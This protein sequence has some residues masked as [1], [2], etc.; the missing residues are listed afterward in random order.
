MKVPA[1]NLRQ[2]GFTLLE[3]LIATAV[4]LLICGAIFGLL[5]LSQ[6][7]YGRE[8]QISS[9]FQEARLAVDQI[10]SDFNRSGYPSLAMFSEVPSPSTYAYGPVAWSPGYTA[11]PP[12]PC[13]VGTAGGGTCMSPGDFDLIVETN[14]GS[15]VNWIRYQLVGTTL[16]RAVVPKVTGADPMAATAASGVMV[17]F[18]VNVMNKA[19]ATQ[20]AEIMATYPTMFPG[21]QPV[22]LFRFTCDVPTGTMP[23]PT[24]GTAD[25]VTNIRDVD[26]TLIVSTTLRDLQTQKWKLVELNGRGHRSNP[27]H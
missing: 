3:L 24:A 11:S 23:C 14:S 8:T 15:G 22:P 9:S 25:L 10:V 4:F 17:P 13:Q 2:T 12:S 26:V 20:M 6:K 18:I 16:F 21:A 7:N 1:R 27:D 5:D 19:P